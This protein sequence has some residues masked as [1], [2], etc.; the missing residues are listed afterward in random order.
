MQAYRY[1]MPLRKWWW[2]LVGAGVLAGVTSILSLRS[3]PPTYQ[4]TSTLIVG[5]ALNNPNPNSGEFYLSQ[6]LASIYASLATR[7]PI[8]EAVKSTLNLADLPS[9]AVRALPENQLIEISV[10]DTS[11]TRARDVANEIAHQLI[12]QSPSSS[13]EAE[14]ARANFVT[15]Q[16]DF[17]QTQIEQTLAD[18]A[19][20]QSKMAGMVSASD[21]ERAQATLD[22]LQQRLLTFQTNYA[23]IL[24]SSGSGVANIL[25]VFDSAQLPRSTSGPSRL[26]I[27]ALA[28]VLGVG[29]ATGGAYLV[30]FLDIR[31]KTPEEIA[32]ALEL[33]ILGYI[34]R[35]RRLKNLTLKDF[36]DGPLLSVTQEFV[37][38][39]LLTTNL[40]F[41][42]GENPP[43]SLLVTSLKT[44]AGKTTVASLLATQLAKRGL[45]I[46][47]VDADLRGPDIQDIFGLD[48]HPGMVDALRDSI[49][50]ENVLQSTGDTR[51]QVI[52]SGAVENENPQLIKP[53]EVLRLLAELENKTDLVVIDSPPAVTSET[54]LLASKVDTVLLIVRPGEIEARTAHVLLD[55]LQQSQGNILG[56]V[57][58][59]IPAYMVSSY[60]IT[61]YFGH[62]HRGKA[63]KPAEATPL[64]E[65]E[66]A[67]G[68]VSESTLALDP[69]E[70]R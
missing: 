29:M 36:T 41:R 45:R 1:L 35:T 65:L 25:R 31:L 69:E 9:Y 39:D 46:T 67:D 48:M 62:V 58:N 68:E 64:P 47:L 55:Q 32:A 19:D 20:L 21:L 16:L 56:I 27:I 63:P 57:V 53:A 6:Q 15:S 43:Q 37:S 52:T 23:S 44:S 3:I 18:I 42:F 51:L 60:G 4:A 49:S 12:L 11:P 61:P 54:L 13:E 2:L 28:I 40:T 26:I 70:N 33:P 22:T 10:T 34:P 7:E 17:L 30:E 8:R 14:Q 50:F 24:S 5:Q 59:Q 38:F 66:S